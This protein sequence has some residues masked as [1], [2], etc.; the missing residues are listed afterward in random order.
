MKT[1]A[2]DRVRRRPPSPA[3]RASPASGRCRASS[4]ARCARSS[5]TGRRRH[6]AAGDRRGAH[7]S[8]ACTPA[9]RS[10]AT[11]TRRWT[12][13]A[14]NGLLPPD[15]AVLVSSRAD[16]PSTRGATRAAGPT[17]TGCSRGARAASSSAT[18][19]SGGPRA[20]RPRR[21]RHAARHSSSAVTTSPRSRPS[22]TDTRWFRCDV[23]RASVARRRRACW[24]S[25]SR[26]TCSCATWSGCS[27]GRCSTSRAAGERR[28][29]RRAA[30]GRPR[31]QAGRTAP[32][33]GLASGGRRLVGGGP[34]PSGAHGARPRA[35]LDGSRMLNVLLTND[36]GIEAEGLQALRRA[37][38]A[39]D[40][41]AWRSSP[42][43]ETARRW[44]ARSRRAGR[45]GSSESPS[46]TA[47]SATPPTARPST[48]CGWRASGC[49]RTSRPTCRRRDQPRRE[50]RR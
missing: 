20:A 3:G 46:R 38:A 35:M 32:A 27:S 8:R 11:R 9:G 13:C 49:R 28:R 23:T 45:C 6:A 36:D 10:R 29:V 26:R 50:P 24:S 15:I 5:A 31:A 21:A 33:H 48:A 12:R 39:L 2:D 30:E 40:G 43:T 14:L 16:E 1:Q 4:S 37:L 22:E 17:A 7:R 34:R 25:G 19:P 42:R 41:C 18:A 44:P 47:P